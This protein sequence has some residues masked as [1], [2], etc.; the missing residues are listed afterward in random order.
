MQAW[1]KR[2]ALSFIVT[3]GFATS[4]L[5]A[6]APVLPTSTPA[7][8]TPSNLFTTVAGRPP[9]S[10]P[11]AHP[12]MNARGYCCASDPNWFGC[13]NW[14]TFSNFAFGSCRSFFF[15]PCIPAAPRA[16]RLAQP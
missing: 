16:P 1:Y 7:D 4:R 12:R 2:L 3:L 5:P 9:N 6:Q 10:V 13:G 8:P 14:H 11:S 15:E